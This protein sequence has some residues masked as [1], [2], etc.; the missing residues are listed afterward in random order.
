M[1]VA[2][3]TTSKRKGISEQTLS[4]TNLKTHHERFRLDYFQY[5]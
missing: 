2:A 5:D 3:D 4:G 1:L